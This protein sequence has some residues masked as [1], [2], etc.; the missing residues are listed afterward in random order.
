VKRFLVTTA[1]ERTWPKDRPVLFLGEWCRLYNRKSVWEGLDSEVVPYHWDDRDKLQRDYDY[2]QGLYE[3]LLGQLSEQ[4]NQMHGVN[5]SL[6][7]WR[8]L[9]GP[10]LGYFI[11]MLFDRWAML[12]QAIAKHDIDG[13][14]VLARE[15]N[16]I[17]P[18]D[19]AHF[20]ALFLGDDWN[21]TI[22]TQLLQECW[23]NNIAI[24]ELDPIDNQPLKA[25][26]GFV[27]WR[28]RLKISAANTVTKANRWI[29]RSDEYFFISSYLPLLADLK[30]QYR[31]GQIPKLW[32]SVSAPRAEAD[33]RMRQWQ[34][35]IQDPI[36]G[37]V[38]EF[39][40]IAHRMIPLHI[41]I[42]YLEGYKSL[43]DCIENLPWPKQPKGIFTCNAYSSDDVFKGWAAEKT[44]TGIPLVIGQ[45]G[46]HFGMTPWAFH[47]EHQ[48]TIAD[49]WIS[50]GWS[51]K[52]NPK[53]VPVGN[54]KGFGRHV[55][56]DSK[57]EALM[58]EMTLPRYS[59]HMY[60]VPVAGQWLSYF[61][62]QCCFV[63]ALPEVLRQ[64]VLVRLYSNDFGW[65]QKERWRER[66][67]DLQLDPGYQS[68]L[69]LI[70]KC[71]IYISTYNATTYLES[72]AWNVPTII[73]W[74][75]AHWELR[76]DVIPHFELLKSVGIF[77]E[78]P[79]SAAQQMVTVWDDIRSWW[80][81][82]AVQDARSEFCACYSHIPDKPLDELET[83]LRNIALPT[84]SA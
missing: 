79:E 45:H 84:V 36:A 3:T 40:R 17:I 55:D 38:D 33:M 75:P 50:W 57:G 44:E 35:K 24:E 74:N 37:T 72:L 31:L 4:L 25:N 23:G 48:I 61:E 2:L 12:K 21:E 68:I 51:D 15:P 56:Y 8:I 43:M 30:L 13:C 49:T 28:R 63:S 77:H 27:P 39:F 70:K 76:D 18:N 78:T 73:F 80:E 59:Y 47:E 32:R 11:Q 53:I 69:T 19:M 41:P 67:P 20:I 64:Q 65:G 34:W 46:G 9:V 54:L 7:Y 58:V 82:E 71:R 16:T 14:R 1:N 62:D 60:A 81:S 29:V 26:V 6:R 83:L 10:W 22:Y 52:K 42:A 66:F 5:H